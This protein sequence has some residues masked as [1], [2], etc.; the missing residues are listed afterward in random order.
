V[1][2]TSF[3][4]HHLALAEIIAA[5]DTNNEEARVRRFIGTFVR[6]RGLDVPVTPHLADELLAIADLAPRAEPGSRLAIACLRVALT[7]VAA[8]A[9]TVAVLGPW[10]RGARGSRTPSRR[11]VG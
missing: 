11:D 8:A 7:P 9:A 2:A 4:E 1:P 3:E 10:L 6:P 5:R